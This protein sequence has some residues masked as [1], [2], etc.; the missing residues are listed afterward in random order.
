MGAESRDVT[1]FCLLTTPRSGST[2]FLSL[3]NSHPQIGAFGEAF[4]N[5]PANKSA[6]HNLAFLPADRFCSFQQTNPAIRPWSTFQ[7][8]DMLVEEFFEG[9]Q[10]LGFKL[11]Y[12]QLLKQV[13]ILP[14]MVRDRY[15]IIHLV[16]EN[17]LDVLI[18]EEITRRRGEAHSNK[19]VESPSVYLKPSSLVRVLK[20]KKV[21]VD[22]A[23]FVL[24]KLPLPVLEVAYESLLQ[25][26]E[27]MLC[28]TTD[29]LS[30]PSYTGY[31]SAFK[32]ISSAP[33]WERIE[34]YEEVREALVDTAFSSLL[35]VQD[36][37]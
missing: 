19:E 33:D 18:S 7:Y 12:R 8:M 26:L 16:R 9:H 29:F 2:W 24:R 13:E 34:N 23:R 35:D 21:R 10:A 5:K 6:W 14:K 20:A 28:K 25:D 1:R 31:E 17:Y 22:A 27:A 11:M 30:V 3:L 36:N 32:K 37:T 4:L 15:H